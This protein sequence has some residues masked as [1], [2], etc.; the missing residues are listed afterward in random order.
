M[1]V[2]RDQIS[3]NFSDVHLFTNLREQQVLAIYMPF[4]TSTYRTNTWVLPR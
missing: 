4:V 1:T 2:G 3:L